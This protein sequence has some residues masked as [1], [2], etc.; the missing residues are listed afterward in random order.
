MQQIRQ[1]SQIENTHTNRLHTSKLQITRCIPLGGKSKLVK[2]L[3]WR[4][5]Y[6]DDDDAHQLV[7]KFVTQI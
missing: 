3:F 2:H 4:K 7:N 5:K 6:D 1:N